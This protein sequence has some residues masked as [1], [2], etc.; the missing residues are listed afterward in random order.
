MPAD[1]ARH[2]APTRPPG[3]CPG[4]EFTAP[5]A[6]PQTGGIT[7]PGNAR[8]LAAPTV[9]GPRSCAGPGPDHSTG[10]PPDLGP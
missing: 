10:Y 2:G 1:V 6:P 3:H 7:R 4:R 9:R 5:A 8:Q